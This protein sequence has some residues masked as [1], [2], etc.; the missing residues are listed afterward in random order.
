MIDQVSLVEPVFEDGEEPIT[1]TATASTVS[2]GG[3]LEGKENKDEDDEKKEME[4]NFRVRK[5]PTVAVITEQDVHLYKRRHKRALNRKRRENQHYNNQ[6]RS[7]NKIS[8]LSSPGTGSPGTGSPFTGTGSPGT[9]SPF[10]GTGVGSGS[11]GTGTG[12][13]TGSNSGSSPTSPSTP[14]NG[15]NG[16]NGFTGASQISSP[17]LDAYLRK[18][19]GEPFCTR[20][21]TGGHVV[22]ME[23]S[24]FDT[25]EDLEKLEAK[26]VRVIAEQKHVQEAKVRL[27]EYGNM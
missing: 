19:A 11:P 1:T 16:N 22:G 27:G 15:N 10:T 2:E 7:A 18:E 24:H 26:R 9:G 12:V 3:G 6:H 20:T 25:E 14:L 17:E 5:N 21:P 4:S 23:H 13:G 8:I